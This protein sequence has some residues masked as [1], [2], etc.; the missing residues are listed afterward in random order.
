M[1]LQHEDLD[2]P[3]KLYLQEL[4][5]VLGQCRGTLYAHVVSRECLRDPSP[6][7]ISL[8]QLDNHRH[9]LGKLIWGDEYW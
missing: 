1:T 6:G 2:E 8:A 5:D 7:E 3:T 9:K 4:L